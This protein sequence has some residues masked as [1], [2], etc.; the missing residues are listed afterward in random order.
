ME[1]GRDPISHTGLVGQLT[2]C[3]SL[4]VAKFDCEPD[5]PAPQVA[6]VVAPAIDE[7]HLRVLRRIQRTTSAQ[8]ILVVASITEQALI[9]ALAAGA[10]GVILREQATPDHLESV[11]N[12]VA[13]QGGHLPP[14]LLGTFLSTIGRVEA[15]APGRGLAF[16]GLQKREVDVLRLL[17]EGLDTAE[18]AT[19]LGWSDRTIKNIILNVRTRLQLRNRT[20]AVAYAMREGL[21]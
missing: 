13:H 11:I 20:H 18:I 9:R 1:A 6:L 14:T 19:K 7:Q 21:I 10:V 16:A 3:P 4:K 5:T 8:S 17:A 15:N 2:K 12:V